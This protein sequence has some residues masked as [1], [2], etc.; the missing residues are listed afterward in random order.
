MELFAVSCTTCQARLKVRDPAAI[1]KILACPK[2][3]SMVQVVAPPGWTPPSTDTL[4]KIAAEAASGNTIAQLKPVL[5]RTNT[6]ASPPTPKPAKAAPIELAKGP[7][8]S[9]KPAAPANP[10][11][12]G[13]PAAAAKPDIAATQ[14]VAGAKQPTTAAAQPTTNPATLATPA[15]TV[16]TPA[17]TVATT[18]PVTP[19]VTASAETAAPTGPSFASRVMSEVSEHKLVLLTT[20][21]VLLVIA[22]FAWILFPP[23]GDST[24]GLPSAPPVTAPITDI[25]PNAVPDTDAVPPA[26]ASDGSQAPEGTPA[27]DSGDIAARRSEEPTPNL[28]D[29][30]NDVATDDGNPPQPVAEDSDIVVPEMPEE[31]AAKPRPPVAGAGNLHRPIVPF[32]EAP[33]GDAL[34]ATADNTAKPD[35]GT[36]DAAAPA[37]EADGDMAD[38][39]MVVGHES[40]PPVDVAARLDDSLQAVQFKRVPLADYCEFLSRMSTIP[41]TLDID[42]LA[43]VNV[44]PGDPVSVALEDTTVGD[45]LTEVL[46]KRGLMFLV[47]GQQLI[48]TSP[49]RKAA[50][51]ASASYDVQDLAGQSGAD[52]AGVMTLVTRYVNPASWQEN[53]GAGRAKVAD[54]TLLVEQDPITQHNIA[55][56]LNKLRQARGLT[57]KGDVKPEDVLLK[58]KYSRAKANLDKQVTANFS[59]ES[60][61]ID[62]LTWLGRTTG[63]RIVIDEASLAQAGLWSHVPAKVVAEKQP[64]YDV[65][66]ALLSPIAMTYRIVD[67][68]TVQ[69]FARQS[70]NARME[71]EIYPLK[72]LLAARLEPAEV[73]DRLR[74]QFDPSSWTEGGGLGAM[75]F[76]EPSQSL[77]VV[78]TPEA[79]IR[80]ENLLL[81]AK[82]GARPAP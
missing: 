44:H 25:A 73:V 24:E 53:G 74:K 21:V 39:D 6:P 76:D 31:G 49:D 13:K 42:A 47:D 63:T 71:V 54:G 75:E 57:L 40:M 77:L 35:T 59:L 79:Q 18:P 15:P 11:V 55:L 10:D 61:L 38:G 65:L 36:P 22:L 51:L 4:N 34:P 58:S 64:L 30:A 72:D 20:P 50:K 29:L 8:A 27:N 62:V 16:A 60:P 3:G 45:A 48:V 1:G 17:P 41:I 5:P 43:M 82:P 67:E 52:I 56:F 12:S 68:R 37:E 19:S 69:V 78:Q 33:A 80:L 70:Q 9:A 7:A 2:C 26:V 14:R 81:R 46:A 28:A 66:S 23:A 32:G